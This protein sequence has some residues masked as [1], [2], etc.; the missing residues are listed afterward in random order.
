MVTLCNGNNES[1]WENTNTSIH[2]YRMSRLEIVGKID[3]T[4]SGIRS[5]DST[6]CWVLLGR[7]NQLLVKV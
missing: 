2:I 7:C 3:K 1:K 5:K 4:N 6:R